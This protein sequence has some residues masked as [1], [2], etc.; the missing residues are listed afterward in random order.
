MYTNKLIP[1]THP[2]TNA[3]IYNQ[4]VTLLDELES[5]K[6]S[7]KTLQNIQKQVNKL[8]SMVCNEQLWDK[9]LKISYRKIIKLVK[10]DIDL[11][12]KNYYLQHFVAIGL[13]AIGIPVGV[14]IG[15]L[16]NNMILI[17]LG[18]P[19][20]LAIGAAIGKHLDKK[21]FKQHKQLSIDLC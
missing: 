10:K 3:Y 14:L 9:Q 4:F 2:S 16:L 18:V 1:A 8:N 19:F 21:A 5:H 6:L 15:F 11:V 13:S 20:G 17:S 7:T 12:P